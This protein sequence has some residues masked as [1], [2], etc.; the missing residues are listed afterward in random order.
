VATW[1]DSGQGHAVELVVDSTT[2]E[3]SHDDLTT[4]DTAAKLKSEV[5]QQAKQELAVFFHINRDGS[6][7]MSTGAEPEVW[8][9][10]ADDD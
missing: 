4:L 7:A 10:D 2:V 6:L 9:E 1:K 3:I 5:E 8:P